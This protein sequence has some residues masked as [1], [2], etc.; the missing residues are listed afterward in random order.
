MRIFRTLTILVLACA[1]AAVPIAGRAQTA[2]NLDALKVLLPF[3]VLL[4]TPAGRAA[5]ASN[6]VVTGSIQAGTANQPG[7]QPLEQQRQQALRDAYITGANA[8]ELAD[9]LGSKL[10][11]AYQALARSTSADDG[12]TVT[13]TNVAPSL[14]T[15]IGYTFAFTSSDAG[16]A[17]FFFANET[18]VTKTATI[19]VSKAAA[20]LF[21]KAG[22]ATD[23]FGIAYHHPAGSAGAD[24]YGDSRPFQTEA[25]VSAYSASDYFGITASNTDYLSGPIQSLVSSPSFPSGHTTYGYTESLLLAMLVPQRF[26]QMI[27]RGAEYGNSRIVL[28][29]HYA[30]DVIAGRTLAYYDV[31]HLL[32]ASPDYVPQ[33]NGPF[34]LTSYQTALEAARTDLTKALESGCGN[35]AAVCAND[36]TSRFKDAATNAAFY[37]STQTYGLPVVYATTGKSVEDVG[38]LAP[39]AGYIL[40]AAY[41]KLTLAQADSILTETE[42]PGGGFLDNG[43]PFGVYSRLD[44]Y[45]A[46]E[47]AAAF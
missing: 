29:A 9:G 42:G 12:K 24:P 21:A 28:G 5:L 44:L 3:S 18:V 16:S 38:A 40:K 22:G 27:A 23:V 33:P 15:L 11:A 13:N 8:C 46:G 37:E 34:V 30:M 6:Y 32:A 4:S 31:A 39:E 20:D 7:L 14:E 10:A 2:T 25:N 19:P 17:K 41:P 36:D 45:R 1:A 43:S 35:S 47:K 26:L